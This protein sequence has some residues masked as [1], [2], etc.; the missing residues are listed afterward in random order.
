MANHLKSE[1]LIEKSKKEVELLL[2]ESEWFGWNDSIKANSP[3]LWNYNLGFKPGALNDMQEC[4]E[5]EFKN[6]IVTTIKQYQ[7]EKTFE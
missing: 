1:L 6:N 5:I 4:V 2:G 7:L 3:E